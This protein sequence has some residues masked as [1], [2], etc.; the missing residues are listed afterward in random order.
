H[1]READF[2]AIEVGDVYTEVIPR[3]T[4]ALEAE[5]QLLTAGARTQLALTAGAMSGFQGTLEARAGLTIEGWTSTVLSGNHLNE[6]ALASGLLALSFNDQRDLAGTEIITL[7]LRADTDLR[8]SDYLRLT[9]RI[10]FPEA[11]APD[12]STAAL[13]FEFT[14]APGG[15]DFVLHQNFPN[16][17]RAQ[18]TIEYDL[19]TA[20]ELTL[21]VRDVR[22]RLLS[23]RRLRGTA[24]R[25]SITLTNDDLNNTT[26]ILTYSLRMGQERLTKRMTVIAR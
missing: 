11:L 3:T 25:N 18:T 5:D 26:G 1:N 17:V 2:V 15:A 4:L 22:G 13:S 10:T 14:D 16:P 7:Q 20:G 21:E 9:D 23:K 24:G 12:G 6:S 19:P 8:I